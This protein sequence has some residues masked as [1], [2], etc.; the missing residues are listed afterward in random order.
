MALKSLWVTLTHVVCPLRDTMSS[1]CCMMSV[2][3]VAFLFSHRNPA[4]KSPLN[5]DISFWVFY[6]RATCPWN[7]TMPTSARRSPIRHNMNNLYTNISET[8]VPLLFQLS[9]WPSGLRRYVQVVVSSGGVGSNPTSDNSFFFIL[10]C[11]LRLTSSNVIKPRLTFDATTNGGMS[12]WVCKC[13]SDTL[14][15]GFVQI[16]K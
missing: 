5:K 4:L 16:C 11:F 10:K 1:L 13:V 7:V 8:F 3:T 15:L 9:G 6:F 12:V 14:D 2:W